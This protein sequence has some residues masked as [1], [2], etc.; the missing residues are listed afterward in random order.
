[1]LVRLSSHAC[2]NACLLVHCVN[3]LCLHLLFLCGP[4]Q[5]P[6]ATS[7]AAQLEQMIVVVC[8]RLSLFAACQAP[9]IVLPS[10][11]NTFDFRVLRENRRVVQDEARRDEIERFHEVLTDISLCQA[12]EAVRKFFIDA[13]VRGAEIGSAETSPVEGNT[14]VFTKRRYRD[15]WNRTVIRRVA[16]VHNQSLKIKAKVRAKGTRGQNWC[17]PVPPPLPP[18]R[19]PGVKCC[20]ISVIAKVRREAREVHPFPGSHTE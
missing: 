6:P 4:R 3:A 14:A 8:A 9:Y 16:K 2:T 7:E 20:D 10:V 17:S 13:Y 12:T 19:F 11:H 5:L 18:T 15:G 1:M